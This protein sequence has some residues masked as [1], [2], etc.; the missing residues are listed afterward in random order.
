MQQV[1]NSADINLL[2]QP[3]FNQ[4]NMSDPMKNYEVTFIVDPVLSAEEIKAT[5]QAYVDLLKN[6]NCE[7][8]H[9]NEMG[10]RQ[11]AYTISKRQSGVYFCIEFRSLSG[12]IIA[13]LELALRRDER[14]MRFKSVKLDRY[15]V[16]YNEDK[17]QGRIG[18]VKK[19]TPPVDRRDDRDS[20]RRDDRRDR[21]DDR[22]DDRPNRQAAPAPARTEEAPANDA[23]TNS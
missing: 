23:G 6:R 20:G 14:I 1:W 21:R 13:E 12:D 9:M 10:L 19:K 22:R 2:L 5:A 16:K 17:R 18:T 7:I 4:P 15:G 3:I 8:V 11:L